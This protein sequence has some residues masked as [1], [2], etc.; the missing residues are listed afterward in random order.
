[1]ATEFGFCA[2][3][4]VWL[5]I[6]CQFFFNSCGLRS[7]LRL[8]LYLKR[9]RF[10]YYWQ[11]FPSLFAFFVVDLSWVIVK[12]FEWLKI[13]NRLYWSH[14]IDCCLIVLE[15]KRKRRDDKSRNI[16]A[17]F[18][19]KEVFGVLKKF[20]GQCKT[21]KWLFISC[22][23]FAD[24]FFGIFTSLFILLWDVMMSTKTDNVCSLFQLTLLSLTAKKKAIQK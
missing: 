4:S 6:H 21:K 13:C 5:Q 1:M 14:M 20:V 10:H 18:I 17:L 3:L 8:N 9:F 16:C 24:V 19:F 22:H 11:N 2:Y 12:S 23:I 15:C 7:L